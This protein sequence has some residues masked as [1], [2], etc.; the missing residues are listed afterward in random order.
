MKGRHMPR[1]ATISAAAVVRALCA[2][3]REE[4]GD[5]GTDEGRRKEGKLSSG[6]RVSGFP[7]GRMISIRQSRRG[8]RIVR[9]E[10]RRSERELQKKIE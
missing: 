6:L 2:Y 9:R 1:Q 10:E 4:V 7:V 5:G 3:G 8:C